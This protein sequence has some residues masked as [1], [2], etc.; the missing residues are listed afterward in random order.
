MR[1]LIAGVAA[2]LILVFVCQARVLA[3]DDARSSRE[4]E[5]LHRAQEALRE[6]QADNSALAQGKAETE[7]KLKAASEQLDTL[8]NANK[9]ERS[10][11]QAKLKATA[12]AQA[13]AASQLEQARR[14][15]AAL[16]T[17]KQEMADK[18]RLSESQLKKVQ[19]D[20][21]SS[22]TANTSCEAKNLKLYEYSQELAQRYQAK[23]V[24]ASLTQ[25]EPVL[26]IANVKVENVLQEYQDKLASQRVQPPTDTRSQ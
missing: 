12:D 6:S 25:H 16:S 22:R 3:A 24:W 10:A 8:R 17:E 18:L 2:S 20:L 21:D 5:M 26:G 7:Q 14:Q 9:S 11:L 13:D 19:Q 15:V 23:G 1:R 4:R